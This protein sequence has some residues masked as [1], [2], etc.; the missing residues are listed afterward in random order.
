MLTECGCA[1]NLYIEVAAATQ[2]N[3]RANLRRRFARCQKFPHER[4]SFR[5][6]G[7][8]P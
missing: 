1:A 7:E 6:E 4:T 8:F 3:P 2:L 5:P